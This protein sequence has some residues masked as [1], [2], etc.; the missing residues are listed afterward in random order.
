MTKPIANVE[1]EAIIAGIKADGSSLDSRIQQA[2]LKAMAHAA[3]HKDAHYLNLLF[4]A[5]SKGHRK[6]AYVAWV[7]AFAKVN[8]NDDKE[9][10]KKVPFVM[11]KTKAGDLQ[12]A[13]KQEW[14]TFKPEPE[15]IEMFDLDKAIASLLKRAG[16]AR[17]VNNPEKLAKL[18][19]L[20]A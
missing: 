18:M 20:Q 14:F 16:D 1:L 10:A 19:A 4:H 2:G 5:L 13:A 9:A 3:D 15:V 12:E 7:I 11:S 6:T 17:A 8:Q